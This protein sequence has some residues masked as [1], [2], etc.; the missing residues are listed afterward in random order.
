M[1]KIEKVRNIENEIRRSE[2]RLLSAK[3][4]ATQILKTIASWSEIEMPKGRNRR[5]KI[6]EKVLKQIREPRYGVS[7][8]VLGL[9]FCRNSCPRD[10][11]FETE[12]IYESMKTAR[13][14]VRRLRKSEPEG[15]NIAIFK[16]KDPM[17]GH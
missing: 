4:G 9:V 17:L 2:V 5:M 11:S 16:Y 14:L 6:L 1:T 8:R 10:L 15:L 7:L 12:F 3:N 13:G